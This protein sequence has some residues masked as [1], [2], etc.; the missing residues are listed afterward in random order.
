VRSFQ[1]SEG[2]WRRESYIRLA[3]EK[4]GGFLV[5]GEKLNSYSIS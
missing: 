1:R 2:M 5:S 4:K 3:K